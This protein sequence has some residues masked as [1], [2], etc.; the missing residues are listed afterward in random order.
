MSLFKVKDLSIY[1]KYKLG[2]GIILW[3]EGRC[4]DDNRGS[5][6]RGLEAAATQQKQEREN[7]VDNVF[8]DLKSKHNEKYTVPQLRLWS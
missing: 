2:D 3:C 5:R 6:K 8:E 1:S 7:R 4:T